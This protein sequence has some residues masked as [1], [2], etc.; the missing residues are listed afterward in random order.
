MSLFRYEVN[1]EDP[2]VHEFME[3]NL[4]GEG[5]F[6]Y[7]WSHGGGRSLLKLHG[8]YMEIDGELKFE[9]LYGT[10]IDWDFI[11]GHYEKEI[12]IKEESIDL[13]WVDNKKEALRFKNSK[14]VL[15][16]HS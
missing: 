15:K 4:S 1:K 2:R 5:T 13:H 7:V 11:I 16:K 12:N 6:E 10:K 9:I 8:T 3:M 14:I